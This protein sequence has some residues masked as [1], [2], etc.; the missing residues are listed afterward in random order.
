MSYS[1]ELKKYLQT[2]PF[3][4][5]CCMIACAAGYEGRPLERACDR[6]AGAFLRGVFFRFGYLTPPNRETLLT[7]TFPDAFAD[8]VFAVL[9]ESGLDVHRSERK[10]KQVLYIK[11]A[12]EVSD[13]LAMMGA[14]RYSLE[15]LQAQV[16]K[17]CNVDLNRQ[18]NAETANL[19]RTANAAA[20]QR[21]AILHLMETKKF[22]L[23]PDELKEAASLRLNHPE[24]NLSELAAMTV[25]PLTK[26]GLN[27][28]LQKLVRLADEEPTN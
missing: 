25:P 14:T 24:A 26:S 11:H 2:L 17:A 6:C 12:D 27:H 23:L 5:E 10:G 7:F 3:K 28:R 20:D 16:D 15:M 8:D 18:V 9:I 22:Q 1:G 21:A 4:N 19:A 13:L